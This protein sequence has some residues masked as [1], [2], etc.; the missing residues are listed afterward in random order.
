[1]YITVSDSFPLY[2]C[3]YLCIP[4]LQKLLG[5]FLDVVLGK[6]CVVMPVTFFFLPVC[7]N[8]V[9]C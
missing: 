8:V 2:I 4:A 6:A 9:L 1:M 5:E 3:H 7:L